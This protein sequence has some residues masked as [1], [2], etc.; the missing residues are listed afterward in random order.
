MA[1]KTFTTGEVL[2][3]ADTNTYLANS[4]LVYITGGTFS[5]TALDGI[6]TSDYDNYRIVV[7]NVTQTGTSGLIQ[8]NFRNT[9]NATDNSALYY[10][11]GIRYDGGTAYNYSINAGTFAETAVNCIAGSNWP[12]FVMDVHAPRLAKITMTT[13]QGTG[14]ITYISNCQASAIM[15]TTTAYAGIIFKLSAGTITGGQITVYGY[16]KA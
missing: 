13:L 3:A 7:S 10:T 1:I 2:T 12:G 16:R 14:A 15:N 6:F 4:G 5:A 11:A 8:Y 9:S